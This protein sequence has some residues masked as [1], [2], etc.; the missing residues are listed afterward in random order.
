[1]AKE[2]GSLVFRLTQIDEARNY[3]LKEI[4]HK[5]LMKRL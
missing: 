5:D 4:K 1:M 3:I 2:N